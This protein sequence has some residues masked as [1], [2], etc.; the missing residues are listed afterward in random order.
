MNIKTIF[1]EPGIINYTL[2]KELR[3]KFSNAT[4]IPIE[5]HNDIKELRQNPNTE[6]AAM[7][8]LLIIGTRKTHTYRKNEK[9][10][11]FL[12]PYTSSGCSAMCLY[13]YLVCHYNKCSYLRLFVNREQMLQKLMRTAS[14]SEK[15]LTFE[16]GSNS[17][18]VLE[19]TITNNLVW[20]IEEFA[21][22][23][24]GFITF[25]T[26]FDM[27]NPLLDLNHRGRTIARMSVNPHE[28][29]TDIEKGTS[30]LTSRVNAIN[31]LCE[32]GYKVGLLI[33]PVILVENW[34]QLYSGLLDRL[35]DTLSDKVKK[36]MFIEVIFMT[37]SY[38]H[39][40]INNEAFPNAVE[41]YDKTIMTG[42]GMG[43]Y[44]YNQKIRAE[45]ES[46][47]REE[48]GKHFSEDKILYIV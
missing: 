16:I 13:C 20:T 23:E 44:T 26:K 19:N 28:I 27:V 5:N 12:V 29:I 9:V 31:R 43:K 6:F 15:D 8:K 47:L 35:A 1:Y 4:W 41:L 25:P 38:I 42:R 40:A 3:N 22:L 32:A 10:S 36:E 11:D 18:L 2:G 37:Y 24:K 30:N 39:R 14:K 21:R 17:D 34:K 33:A 48:I 7:K 45:G 46:F